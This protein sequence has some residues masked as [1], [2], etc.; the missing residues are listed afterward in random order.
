MLNKICLLLLLA[1]ALSFG[2]EPVIEN[3]IRR[4]LGFDLHSAQPLDQKA[5][6][7]GVLQLRQFLR[8]NP[9]LG[10]KIS[11]PSHLEGRGETKILQNLANP[12]NGDLLNE[13]VLVTGRGRFLAHGWDQERNAAVY[14][15][16]QVLSSD[17]LKNHKIAKV[18]IRLIAE[19]AGCLESMDDY[20][21]EPSA[22]AKKNAILDYIG[23]GEDGMFNYMVQDLNIEIFKQD[24]QALIR[25]FTGMTMSLNDE[26]YVPYSYLIGSYQS[27]QHL[28]A[29]IKETIHDFVEAGNQYIGEPQL[30]KDEFKR[31]YDGL[32]A[33]GSV[34][35]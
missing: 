31:M 20:L 24:R 3:S 16:I 17:W 21:P 18:G 29:R 25:K 8:V 33:R 19:L 12:F 30:C 1:P 2:D 14:P 10:L 11:I 34:K 22:Y 15:S 9:E 32:K 13:R 4:K 23:M 5:F 26:T 28:K 27:Y 7:E 6:I 35:Y